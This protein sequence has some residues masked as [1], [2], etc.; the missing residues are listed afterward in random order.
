MKTK[1]K[2]TKTLLLI[3]L[4]LIPARISFS[5]ETVSA[6]EAI[7]LT[8]S[9]LDRALDFYTKVLTFEKVSEVE[10]AGEEYE[11]L[12]G[13]FGLRMRVAR[14]RLGEE[15]IELTDYLAPEGRTVPVDMRSN[16]IR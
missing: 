5:Q 12:Q 7:G 9:D 16:D 6:V 11:Q 1:I 10:V 14:L 3:C 8:V 13:V 2:P 15:F 4:L